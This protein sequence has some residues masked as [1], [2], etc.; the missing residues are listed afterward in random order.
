MG[1]EDRDLV[2]LRISQA[3]MRCA[4]EVL[5]LLTQQGEG[6]ASQLEPIELWLKGRALLADRQRRKKVFGNAMIGEPPWDLL[7][8]LFASAEID[9]LSMHALAEQSGVPLTIAK[10]WLGFLEQQNLIALAAHRSDTRAT[11]VSL[12]PAGIERMQTYLKS[13]TALR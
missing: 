2:E 3:D 5:S 9:G 1:Q 10:R 13:T 8:F 7:L 12:T 6:K 4:V 11:M